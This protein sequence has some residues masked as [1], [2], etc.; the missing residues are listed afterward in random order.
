MAVD[1]RQLEVFFSVMRNG[2]THAAAEEL[3]VSQPA[4]SK[5]LK[6]IQASTGIVLFQKQKRNLVPTDDAQR[7][8]LE[9]EPL[10]TY[11]YAIQDRVR[12]I[13]TRQTGILKVAATSTCASTCVA[14]ALKALQEQHPGLQVTLDV[15]R[16][17]AVVDQVRSNVA[18]VGVAMV[19]PDSEPGLNMKPIHEGQMVCVVHRDH[20][21]AQAIEV[22]PHDLQDQPIIALEQRGSPLGRRIAEAFESNRVTF[23]WAVET[24]FSE[25]ACALVARDVGCALVD[26]FALDSVGRSDLVS[27]PF[28]PKIPITIFGFATPHRRQSWMVKAF[29]QALMHR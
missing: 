25:T 21:L 6:S 14:K 22:G 19:D 27:I 2:T 18:D 17:D 13:R 8:Y 26:E 4:V 29:L 7:L 3:G 12:D 1:F 15:Q 28:V 23:S 11:Y 9:A 20:P 24:G 10:L 5:M 16:M